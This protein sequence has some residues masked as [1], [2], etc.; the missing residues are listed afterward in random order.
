M[1]KSLAL[2][3]VSGVVLTVLLTGTT[4]ASTGRIVPEKS[5][6]HT[7]STTTNDQAEYRAMKKVRTAR[8]KPKVE[9]VAKKVTPVK[10]RTVTRK[11]SKPR[12]VSRPRAAKLRKYAP[13]VEQ[14]RPTV[15]KYLKKY[16]CYTAANEALAVR[17]IRGESRGDPNAHRAGSQYYGLVQCGEG[18]V[19]KYSAD[20]KIRNMYVPREDWGTSKDWRMNPDTSIRVLCSCISQGSVYQQFSTAR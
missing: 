7:A 3:W 20:G 9:H 17:V 14:W 4:A 8:L 1:H 18:W 10:K 11:A 15:I 19:R 12:V 13:G 16:G 5:L 2:L 6:K